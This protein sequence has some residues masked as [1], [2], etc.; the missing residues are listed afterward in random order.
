MIFRHETIAAAESSFIRIVMHF[1]ILLS[2]A[3]EMGRDTKDCRSCW[4]CD[5]LYLCYDVSVGWQYR[6][7]FPFQKLNQ[8]KSKSVICHST[9][10][11][12]SIRKKK[13]WR[14]N[15]KIQKIL[16]EYRTWNLNNCVTP[17]IFDIGTEASLTILNFIGVS[18]I[19]PW[20]LRN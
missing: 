5:V 1:S 10:R 13:K 8:R 17:L 6:R 4:Q 19:I 15:K 16:T 3:F 12:A 20:G 18:W 2:K 11:L 14:Q 9:K 7:P